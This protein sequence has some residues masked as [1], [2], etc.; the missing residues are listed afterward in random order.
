MHYVVKWMFTPRLS[1][2]PMWS[3]SLL[4]SVNRIGRGV[5]GCVRC[6]VYVCGALVE[7]CCRCTIRR[8]WS[9]VLSQRV[10]SSLFGTQMEHHFINRFSLCV[11]RA[12]HKPAGVR[13]RKDDEQE[14][15]DTGRVR[16]SEDDCRRRER[17]AALLPVRCCT[18]RQKQTVFKP[19][20]SCV[21]SCAVYLDI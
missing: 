10:S 5:P 20:T 16:F 15:T 8:G 6:G 3:I 18:T 21:P 17:K 4:L 2:R 14:Q 19:W 9:C 1:T 12:P 13:T 11:R 7:R